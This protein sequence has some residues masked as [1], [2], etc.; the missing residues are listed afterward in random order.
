MIIES[1][2]VRRAFCAFALAWLRY[3]A[4]LSAAFAVALCFAGCDYAAHRD[5]EIFIYA[6]EILARESARLHARDLGGAAV[7]ITCC[8]SML[9]LIQNGDWIVFAP[10]AFTDALLG[11]VAIYQSAAPG[12]NW[13]HRLVAGD[14]ASGF[15]A[16]G[17]NNRWS[18]SARYVSQENFRGVVLAIYRAEKPAS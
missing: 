8:G 14:A 12:E 1:P 4:P 9:P 5:P 18:E 10:V 11:R 3:L 6:T 17:D 13:V 7:Q 15:I 16:S 2:R